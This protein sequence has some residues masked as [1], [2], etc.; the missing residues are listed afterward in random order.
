MSFTV[1]DDE[2]T[3]Y[4]PNGVFTVYAGL[5]GPD[6]VSSRL[7]GVDCISIQI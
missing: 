3:R 7:T 6:A 4:T 5:N 2:G 1:V